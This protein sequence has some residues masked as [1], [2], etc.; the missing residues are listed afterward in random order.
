[1]KKTLLFWAVLLISATSFAQKEKTLVLNEDTNL[2]EATYYHEN[3]EISQKGTFN[4]ARK[5]HGEWA[6]FNE[7][8]EKIAMGSYENGVK[9]GKWFFW[10]DGIVKEVEYNNNAIAG[11]VNKESKS[12]IVIKD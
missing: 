4:L 8:G 7:K 3:G 12:G 10:T 11:V 9:T 5:L 1:M 6:S 2:I